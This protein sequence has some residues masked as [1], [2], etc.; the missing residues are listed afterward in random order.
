MKARQL[1]SVA[2]VAMVMATIPGCGEKPETKDPVA[3]PACAD[4]DKV[5]DPAQRAELLEKCP[6]QGQFK[7]SQQK[8]W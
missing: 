7:P 4:L 3:S 6:R 5:Q 2:L 8:A 1:S